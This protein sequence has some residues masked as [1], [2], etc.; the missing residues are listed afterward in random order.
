M[1]PLRKLAERALAWLRSQDAAGVEA[2]LYLSRST[3]RGVELRAGRLD[4]VQESSSE[5]AGLRLF[6]QGRMGFASA[7][8][9]GLETVQALY[10][11]VRLQLPHLEP[12]PHKAL[13]A[14]APG[15]PDEALEA[16]LW[17]ETLFRRGWD[18]IVP[19]LKAVEAEVLARDKRIRSVL[20]LGYG[21]SSGE[22]VIA[23]TRGV[24]TWERGSSAS[25]GLSA[26]GAEDGEV[27]VGSAFQSAR[28]EADLD[29]GRAARE[30]AWRTTALLG[31]QKLPGGRRA[32]IFDPW[33]AG[34]FLDL[35][36]GLLCADQI[37]RG[38]SLLAGKL[39]KKV[40][41]ELVAFV[42]DPRR[43]GGLA[44]S[45]YDD[46]G[47]PTGRKLLVEAG[48]VRDYFYDTYTAAKDGRSSNASAARGSYKGLP[49][50]GSSNFYLVAGR[51]SRDALISGTA[52]G[53]L[54]LDVMGMHMVDPISGEL[55][56][57]VSGLAVRDGR[58][59]QPVKGA[60]ISGNLMEFLERIDAV[61]DD[62]TF[63]GSMGSPTFRV[64][65][66]TVA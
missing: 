41:S 6:S 28:K 11:K 9:T 45:L 3:E 18:E 5:G 8:G 61:A 39:G 16:S 29:F 60:M 17:D 55:S 44:S 33:V 50:P 13:P 12:D 51:M 59:A 56:V 48:V 31:G 34:E 22:V 14:A 46:E 15:R 38:K 23:S 62:L 10:G 47:V 37:Q 36:S 63:Y 21:E 42:D 54:V 24:S 53:I 52:D 30:A 40:A 49:G 26:L 25:V 32:V 2:E 66:M 27:Q 4:G 58:L 20:R 1:E 65:D 35:I 43:P 57:G 7:G 64:A 19:R